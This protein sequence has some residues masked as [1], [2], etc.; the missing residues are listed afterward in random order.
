MANELPWIYNCTNK[1]FFLA[2]K[3]CKEIL[4]FFDIVILAKLTRCYWEFKLLLFFLYLLKQRVTIYNLRL[5][6]F[7]LLNPS[8]DRAFGSKV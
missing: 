7:N 6:K 2:E 1:K 4:L 3:S 8:L 5:F